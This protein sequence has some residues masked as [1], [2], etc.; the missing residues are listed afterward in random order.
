M[1]KATQ[2]KKFN[3]SPRLSFWKS[4]VVTGIM[5]LMGT[6]TYGQVDCNTIMACND[7][8]QI[9][10][11]ANCT[12]TVMPDMMLEDQAYDNEFYNVLV[13]TE[14][15]TVI[16]NNVLTK[17]AIGKT[18]QVIV[19]LDGCD[20]SCWG[21]ITI[22]DKLPPVISNCPS[23]TVKCGASTA[24]GAIAKPTAI[25][26][27]STVT[28]TSSDK[29]II[30]QCTA[31][32]VKVIT[33]TWTATDAYGNKT[34]CQ[35][36]IN[37]T[38]PTISDVSIPKNYDSKEL[39]VF[40]CGAQIKY[41]PNGAPHPDVTGYPGGTDCANIMFFYNDVVFNICG[42][43]IKVLRQ[44]TVIDWCTGK[45]TVAGQV[46]KIIDDAPPIC[47]SP[48]DFK[49]DI[50]TD[51][52]KCTGTFKVPAPNVIFEC[53]KYDYIVG[54]K[55]RTANGS[56]FVNPVYDNVTKTT[57]PDGSYFYT[58][59]N[60]PAD[61]S[62][63]VYQITDA[64]GHSS[65]CFTEVIVKDKEAPSPVCEGFTVVSIDDAGVGDLFAAS[66]DNG[67]TDNCGIQKFQIKRKENKCG[68]PED[69]EFRDKVIFCCADVSSD[70][71]VYQQVVLR[72]FDKSGNFS[73]CQSNVKVQDKKAPK[74]TIPPNITISCEQDYK[75]LSLTGGRPTAV[76]NCSVKIDS[77]DVVNLK[78][79]LGTVNRTWRVTDSQGLVDSKVQIITIRDNTPFIKDNIT[80]PKDIT[81]NGC[82][83]S[84]A[85]P[86]KLNSKPTY[87][88]ADCA[89]IAISKDDE[90]YTYAGSC[91]NIL[92]T[93][94]VVNWCDAN[95]QNPVYFTYVQKITLTNSVPPVVVSGCGPRTINSIENDCEEYVE[96]SITATDD[97]T[98]A[99]SLK[100]T[101][102]YDKDN[103][104]TVDQ[105]GTGSFYA[106]VYPAGKHKM[107]FTV[108]DGCENA[109]TCSYIFT[110]K[111]NKPPTPICNSQVTWVLDEA[112]K[113]TVWAS[114]FDLKS[115]D[116]CDGSKLKFSFT[117]DGSQ[118]S[119]TFTCSDVPNGV[120]ATIP[121]KMYVID[122]D[123]NSEFCD[124]KLILQDSP[125]KNACPNTGNLT[126]TISGKVVNKT[127]EA[128]SEIPVAL[129]NKNEST[130]TQKVT[131]SEGKFIFEEV[132]L[133]N[134]YMVNPVKKDEVLNGV[135][136][137]DLVLIQRHILGVKSIENPYDLIAAD[138]NKDKKVTASDLVSLR[139]VILGIDNNFSSNNPWR[140]VPASYSFAD[141]KFPHDFPQG[142]E[143]NEFTTDAENLNFTAVKTGD[144]NNSATYNVKNTVNV[145]ARTAPIVFVSNKRP[146]SAN[147]NI[148]IH[149]KVSDYVSISGLQMSLNYDESKLDLLN[150]TSS[151]LSISEENY[152][153]TNG[154]VK[155]SVN[156]QTNVEAYEGDE[157]ITLNFKAIKEG[158]A[159]SIQLNENDFAN[160]LYDSEFTSRGIKFELLE[161]SDE[162]FEDGIKNH[163]N[164]FSEY[165]TLQF[166]AQN[167]GTA[168]L[169]V[170]D[171]TGKLIYKNQEQFVK[172]TNKI[173][174]KKEH[175]SGHNGI[176]F[177]QLE[178]NG[179]IHS[180]AM[181][182]SE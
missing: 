132:P 112:G 15:G 19:T 102:A 76:D 164:P 118:A 56:P 145:E 152:T 27:C 52:G 136:T 73:D 149:L 2:T 53:S 30:S 33:R 31:R 153:H 4:I 127:D 20:L 88:N 180:G 83:V 80:F 178:I 114:D 181:I 41:L 134:G 84:D 122:S 77:V 75:N 32:F 98:P 160:E 89:D 7:L 37:V 51:E 48:P 59:K 45:D 5:S 169:K 144:V 133:L 11:G 50:S 161:S 64:C 155:I 166:A 21:N 119:K 168:T 18:Y 107:T 47:V 103:N 34:T 109:T 14:N 137:L 44:W 105:T 177:Y 159:A 61:T 74:I 173:I 115:A 111:D 25:D 172:G 16:P 49:F 106:K 23:A 86:E 146:Y 71:K 26:A 167:D 55:L 22:E 182:L 108:K 24:P 94:R 35:Q 126:G 70:P 78:C 69:L 57:L 9:S 154:V 147:Q 175:L 36:T 90:V 1:N 141:P 143:L 116:L 60:L 62:W 40:T 120:S 85:T 125:N 174:V 151:K 131:T 29:E 6:A 110:V 171:A 17:S 65:E 162:R 46:I 42:A 139:K 95:P 121:L 8:V 142:I 176:Y 87:V 3:N 68:R 124:V 113:A 97:C 165:T 79:G 38:R 156:Q 179:T 12:E 63:I 117:A 43:S 129:E 138:I 104:G 140:F 150:I 135:S 101:W 158:D 28:L 72:V 93:W 128:F 13:K 170:M 82:Q 163:P 92:R 157:I 81:V 58:I 54:Y 99:E 66:I 130:T 91:L 96:H 100:Y 10:L 39:P 123:G 148:S 67:S